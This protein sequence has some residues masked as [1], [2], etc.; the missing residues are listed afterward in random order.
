MRTY[1]AF[2]CVALLGAT[3]PGCF[4]L[5]PGNDGGLDGGD[6][7]STSLPDASTDPTTID[8]RVNGM[9][10]AALDSAPDALA[11]GAPDALADGA[12][13]V[14]MDSG[15]DANH[16]ATPDSGSM[17]APGLTMCA[18][19]VDT[20][21]SATN[22]G[23]CG[24]S[25][26]AGDVCAA[27]ICGRPRLNRVVPELA[28]PGQDVFLEGS[29][30]SAGASVLFPGSATPV[31]ATVLGAGRLRATVPMDATA[32][33]LT[34]TVSGTPTN[35]VRFRRASF[36]LSLQHFRSRYEQTD[37]ARQ[38]PT[39]TTARV[40]AASLVVPGTNSDW[41]YLFGGS[42][43]AGGARASIERAMIN[44]D[45]TLG[46]FNARTEALTR[47]RDGARAVRVG[48]YVYVLGGDRAVERSTVA[49]DG[50]LGAFADAGV[51]LTVS[52]SNMAVVVI[53]P[54]LYVFGGGSA[55]VERAAIR[56]DDSLGAFETVRVGATTVTTED[57]VRGAALVVGD[58]VYLFGGRTGAS[59]SNTSEFARIDGAGNL[60]LNAGRVF[61]V[62]PSMRARRD[63]ATAQLIGGQVFLLGGDG[64]MPA[65]TSIERATI[66]ADN[67]LGA[68]AVHETSLSSA[69]A[70]AA[71]ATVGNYLY[72]VGGTV[73][74]SASLG[75][76]R[77]QLISTT[78]TL[79]MA[80]VAPAFAEPCV[81][82][83]PDGGV[84]VIGHFL[85]LFGCYPTSL[86]SDGRFSMRVRINV[87]GSLG[88]GTR[89]MAG[90]P[91]YYSTGAIVGNRLIHCGGQND[92]GSMQPY[93]GLCE[94]RAISDSAELSFVDSF[95]NLSDITGHARSVVLGSTLV[96][97]GGA[98]SFPTFAPFVRTVSVN[99]NADLSNYRAGTLS[100]A[101]VTAMNRTPVIV[102]GSNVLLPSHSSVA[103]ATV[104]F[105]ANNL[106]DR[107][108]AN[109]AFSVANQ[110]LGVRGGTIVGGHY[111]QFG[112]LQVSPA[113]YQG[114]I[115][116]APLGA[117]DL[118]GA[119]EQVATS[120]FHP[121][122]V[123]SPI[124]IGN[125]VV[126]YAM[127]TAMDMAP[128]QQ[129]RIR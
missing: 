50:S 11:D 39:L 107:S 14:V 41:L 55:N 86:R 76:D 126:V 97:L 108:A 74:A 40:N 121:E 92:E 113:A 20:T 21:S 19:C 129:L 28:Q 15:S 10:D 65:T 116:R 118:T 1:R 102:L 67:S 2:F 18:A 93:S 49:A 42:D 13:D 63:G 117:A 46:A 53:G 124:V 87:D 78:A 3:L 80:T 47:P 123:T 54:W 27:G 52:R 51:S 68:F 60:V 44:D 34:V 73:G 115:W 104:T 43:G 127:R 119:F 91:R 8:T 36:S 23:A 24:N 75:L 125:S 57:R 12:P 61:D 37:F 58:R 99:A 5:R 45:G 109:A 66:Q 22:C 96:T 6:G 69:R 64:E 72:L 59:A 16:D 33:D 29:F 120:A 88:S 30:G 31:I 128:L 25:C 70:G 48:R 84:V 103:A 89:Y 85:H 95:N 90:G 114:T 106:Y 111:Y 26:G 35:A 17:C 110:T 77:A 112:S 122:W 62:G 100:T 9:P 82:N 81:Q 83:G 105:D 94:R 79:S 56:A 4:S 71:V 32:G 101:T 7:G 98:V 38:T